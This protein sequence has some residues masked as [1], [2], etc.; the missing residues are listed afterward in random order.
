[1]MPPVPTKPDSYVDRDWVK[2]VFH[3]ADTPLRTHRITLSYSMFAKFLDDLLFGEAGVEQ[4]LSHERSVSSA[5]ANW[6]NFATW[7][8]YTLGPNIRNDAAPQRLDSL[9][10]FV[11]RRFAPSVVQSRS[12][13]GQAVG[14][15]LAWGQ[16]LIFF[17]AA[18][19]LL[20]FA[21][22]SRART[23]TQFSM[24]NP[25]RTKILRALNW[26]GEQWV[27]EGHLQLVDEAFECYRLVLHR[28]GELR[29]ARP[30][31]T[32]RDDVLADPTIPKLMLLATS[33]LTAAEQAV[34]NTALAVVID[35]I[36]I[37]LVN[38]I[39]RQ[40][41]RF[42]QRHRG[43]PSQVAALKILTR[44]QG[45]RTPLSDAW[46]RIMTD[47]LLVI[48]LPTEML[49]LG[50]DVPLPN[51]VA[52]MYPASLRNLKVNMKK[53]SVP[54]A[55]E[56]LIE[57]KLAALREFVASFDRTSTGRG[58]AAR[59]WRRFDDRMNWATT[60]FRS[61]QQDPT[62]FWAPY[63]EED[64]KRIGDGNL[65]RASGRPGQN[66]VSPP[67]DPDVINQVLTS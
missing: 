60:L 14:R 59:D 62:L 1:M 55:N 4:T 38:G 37:R 24:P 3:T 64:A 10:E 66:S 49:R 13:D 28:V 57:A 20:E 16:E 42:V 2:E 63:S 67:V 5:N 33:L 36:P 18:N 44:L 58:S 46:A 48:V 53:L 41:A 22:R 35:A 25:L 54:A 39:E 56:A 12:G 30:M 15:A 43:V 65:P 27:D 34:V 26:N 6:F 31:K 23:T 61:R 47:Q 50:R 9:P 32:L 11:R 8:T 7:G 52:P 45:A 40:A 19:A 51:A 29:S 21:K 17:S